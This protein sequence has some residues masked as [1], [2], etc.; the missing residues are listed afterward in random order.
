[1]GKKKR[2]EEILEKRCSLIEERSNVFS[3]GGSREEMRIEA[4][5]IENEIVFLDSELRK[6]QKK[7]K[8]ATYAIA[9]VKLLDMKNNLK[10][11]TV[12]IKD[13]GVP[14]SFETDKYI[15]SKDSLLAC[16]IMKTPINSIGVYK[17][18]AFET[19][20]RV[21]KKRVF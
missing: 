17:T 3:N 14:S 7:E 9:E 10:D 19:A 11:L 2:M 16:A 1:M 6:L 18:G 13:E 20:V 5:N 15:V 8:N 21:L 12:I 4:Q